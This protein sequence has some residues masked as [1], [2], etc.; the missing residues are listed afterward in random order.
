MERRRKIVCYS[1]AGL[2]NA[3]IMTLHQI[4]IIKNMPDIPLKKFDANSITWTKK[5][6]EF[7][8]PDAPAASALYSI[9]MMLATYGGKEGLRRFPLLNKLLLGSI[10]INAGMALQYLSNM[11]FKQ[12][13][14]C[15]YCITASTINTLM[16]PIAFKEMRMK[17]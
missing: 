14:I 8:L 10:V 5:A 17:S 12:K 13:K 7:G 2:F 15:I 16:V 9:I 11:F 6:F 3:S 4:G 1:L